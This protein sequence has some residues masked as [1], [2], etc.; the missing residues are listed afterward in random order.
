MMIFP[1]RSDQVQTQSTKPHVRNKI[2]TLFRIPSLIHPHCLVRQHQVSTLRFPRQAYRRWL[3]LNQSSCFL[4]LVIL[5]LQILSASSNK[6]RKRLKFSC[7]FYLQICA[8]PPSIR[9][10]KIHGN[11]NYSALTTIKQG[12]H[13]AVPN[14]NP[15]HILIET[16]IY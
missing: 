15:K 14:R 6:N 11:N 16:P 9:R 12:N 7:N 2:A 5:A 3:A 4:G 10:M 1:R 13:H 8:A